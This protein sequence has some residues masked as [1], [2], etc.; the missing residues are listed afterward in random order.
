MKKMLVRFGIFFA[1]LLLLAACVPGVPGVPVDITQPPAPTSTPT[2]TP[3][4]TPTPTSTSTPSPTAT[5]TPTSTPMPTPTPVATLNPAG[6]VGLGV[7][8]EAS[9]YDN[10]AAVEAFEALLKHKMM[11]VL[12]FQAWGDDPEFHGDW[13]TLAAQKG[14]TPVIT[15]EPWKRDFVT[16]W[17]VQPEY[18][19]ETI[20]NGDHDDYIRS[21]ARAAKATGV[22]VIIRFA[23]EQSTQIGTRPW[24]P[25]QGDPTGYR[26]AFRHIVEVFR[27]EKADN[28]QFLWSAMWLQ[29][30]AAD[31][32]PGD[33]V[34]DLVGTTILN[35]GLGA[36]ADWAQWRTFDFL[37]SNEYLAGEKWGKPIMLTEV[38]TAEQGGDK[39][40]WLRDAF[41]SIRTRYPLVEAVL[42]LE[43]PVDREWPDI[44]WSVTSSPESLAAFKEAITDPYY[45]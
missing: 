14:L 21:W 26:A 40:A 30:Y 25:W 41:T 36:Q 4:A 35:H 3:T 13:V 19:L 24:Y 45:K 23:H 12:W 2:L 32:Y 38:A 1:W 7:Y 17:A 44:N 18:A 43:M 34:V 9:P 6:K 33:D 10:F 16:P 5:P 27:E 28:V 15:W 39:A 11:Y 42:L 8:F 29:L 22:P 37:F 31:Y 20:V